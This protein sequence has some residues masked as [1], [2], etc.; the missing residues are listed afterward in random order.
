LALFQAKILLNTLVIV[1]E[2]LLDL[3][4]MV[5]AVLQVV[6]AW[7]LRF[8]SLFH[9]GVSLKLVEEDFKLLQMWERLASVTIDSSLKLG[10]NWNEAIPFFVR[11]LVITVVAHHVLATSTKLIDNLLTELGEEFSHLAMELSD[12]DDFFKDVE[13]FLIY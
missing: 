7:S 12:T 3:G 1:T 2:E 9:G 8:D 4:A 6:E 10:V 5:L 11:K 13:Q